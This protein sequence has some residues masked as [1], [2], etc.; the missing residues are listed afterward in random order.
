MRH[1]LSLVLLLGVCP[2]M[3]AANAPP[4]D[5]AVDNRFK[6]DT[7][8]EDIPQPMNLEMAPDGRIFFIEIGGKIKIYHPDTKQV[9]V[10]GSVSV[11]T[12]N[13]CGLLGMALDPKF[14]SNGWIYLL[15]SPN[16]FNGQRIS[17][18]TMMGDAMSSGSAK[19]L[20]TYAE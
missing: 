7:L 2:L 1:T 12:A 6:I 8:I 3:W 11:T 10:A 14:G 20:L 13:E 16:D 19:V 5:P 15:Y 18:Y 9:T 4:V 17:R